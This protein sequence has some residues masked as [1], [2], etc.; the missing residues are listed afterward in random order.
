M[1]KIKN[2]CFV[3]FFEKTSFELA[4]TYYKQKQ[5]ELAINQALD[6]LKKDK[7]FENGAVKVFLLDVFTALGGNDPLVKEGRRKMTSILLV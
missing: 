1:E 3:L 4:K 7:N 6:L 2:N 5:F